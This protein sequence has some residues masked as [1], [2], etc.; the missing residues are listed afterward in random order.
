M[1]LPRLAGNELVIRLLIERESLAHR[2]WGESPEDIFNDMYCGDAA[3]GF[4]RAG[5]SYLRG[6]W[7]YRSLQ[8]YKRA[9]QVNPTCDE[10]ITKTVQLQ[11][12][13]SENKELLV[14]TN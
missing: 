12:I 4:C 3:E 2:F 11:Q 7:F 6:Q 14:G 5:R 10:A 13:V 8:S 1:I 9:I